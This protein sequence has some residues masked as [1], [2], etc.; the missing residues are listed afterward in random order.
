[1]TKR[2]KEKG[3]PPSRPP[4]SLRLSLFGRSVQTWARVVFALLG[5]LPILALIRLTMLVWTRPASTPA[6]L[7]EFAAISLFVIVSLCSGL[8]LLR[9][10]VRRIQDAWEETADVDFAGLA[11]GTDVSVGD[12]DTPAPTPTVES[13]PASDF[14]PAQHVYTEWGLHNE[15]DTLTTTVRRLRDALRANLEAVRT[16]EIRLQTLEYA[17]NNIHDAVLIL[18]ENNTV[19]FANLPARSMLGIVENTNIQRALAESSLP[20]EAWTVLADWLTCWE[21]RREEFNFSDRSEGPRTF[22]VHVQPLAVD[23]DERSGLLK[24]AVIQDLS[25]RRRMERQLLRSE[26][27]AALGQLISGVAHELN[28]PLAAILGFSELCQDPRTPSQDLKRHL[29]I[30]EREARRTQHIVR[31]LLNFSRQR[32][33]ERTAADVRELLDR[34]LSLLSYQ[35]RV[36]NITVER[37]YPDSL[38][39]VHVDEF[40]IQQVFM[41]LMIN[42]SQAMAQAKTSNRKIYVRVRS[43]GDG[44]DVAV[45]IQ[46]TGPGIPP[47]LLDRVFEPFFTTKP[48]GIGTGLGLSVCQAIVSKH[49]G[50]ITVRSRPG[51][52]ATFTVTLPVAAQTLRLKM[53]QKKPAILSAVPGRTPWAPPH[54]AGAGGAQLKGRVLLVDDEVAVC[55]L[56][57]HVLG[58]AGLEVET[59]GSLRDARA[60]LASEKFDALLCDIRLPDGD[61]AELWQDLA[62]K[63]PNLLSST[64]FM[65]GDPR[66]GN[67]L[68]NRLGVPIRVIHKPFHLDELTA[69]VTEL[70]RSAA[71]HR[72]VDANQRNPT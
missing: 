18:D 48:E 25:D 69:V 35:F 46:D 65:T 4:L 57:A 52:G 16:Q 64:A 56:G 50:T 23:E 58:R 20:E 7:V 68:R 51:E 26:R 21:E 66:A 30:I 37:D 70:L 29:E 8:Y 34:C 12:R 9:Y 15:L 19:T 22:H 3:P 43:V 38:P 28:N 53:P 17:V 47:D 44:Q 24:L 49:G 55:A 40:Q 1:L 45:E 72:S 13:A 11:A 54:S 2:P 67:E 5:I 39:S 6:A 33:P 14:D 63:N 71:A 36:L 60:R 42:A 10:L 41:N 27:L 61:V 31:D 62:E 59:A 32:K